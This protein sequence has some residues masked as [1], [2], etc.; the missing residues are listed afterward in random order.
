[1]IK[2]NHFTIDFPKFH[3]NYQSYQ[4]QFQKKFL[5]NRYWCD[6]CFVKGK[7]TSIDKCQFCYY[8]CYCARCSKY[9]TMVR[10]LAYYLEIKGDLQALQQRFLF[11]IVHKKQIYSNYNINDRSTYK[12]LVKFMYDQNKVLHINNT[13]IA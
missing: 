4:C 3:H 9:Q 11:N 13:P 2:S 5:C 8:L 7:K 1:M 10:L 6:Q 12:S